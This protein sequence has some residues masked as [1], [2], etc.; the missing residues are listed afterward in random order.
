MSL[1]YAFQYNQATQDG[2]NCQDHPL[3]V[4]PLREKAEFKRL[5]AD[6][7]YKYTALKIQKV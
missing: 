1:S 2:F 3:M 4:H 5:V 7:E 6:H